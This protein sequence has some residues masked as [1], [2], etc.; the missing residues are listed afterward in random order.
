MKSIIV[1]HSMYQDVEVL[2]P[3]HRLQE[4]GTV[5]VAAEMVGKIRGIQGTEI[6]SNMTTETLN[7][8]DENYLRVFDLL[9]LPGGVKAM[10]K[11]RQDKHA[12]T[13]VKRWADINKPIA[14]ICSG[15]QMI[16]SAR[17]PLKGRRLSAY[18][19]MSIDVEN[20]GAVFVDE[21]AVVNGNII[22]SPHYNHLAVWMK[23]AI[24][25]TLKSNIADD[26][27]T[28]KSTLTEYAQLMVFYG[29][30][31]V[32]ELIAAQV[33]HVNKLQGKLRSELAELPR[34]YRQG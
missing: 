10:E 11:L 1:T 34:N 5:M 6:M 22:S 28:L 23:A 4:E 27:A 9:V 16:L 7:N 12:L 24:E 3:F 2:Y 31:T 14:S 33:R 21:P 25:H 20:A 17:V 30:S 15:A 13:F 19:A 8:S 29:V 26:L 32:S 18:P